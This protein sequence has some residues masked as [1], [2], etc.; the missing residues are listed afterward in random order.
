[1]L[2]VA[3]YDAPIRAFIETD[4]APILGTLVQH[5]GFVLEHQQRGARSKIHNQSHFAGQ[6]L[7]HIR[8]HQLYVFDTYIEEIVL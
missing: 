2:S 5:H 1:M 6:T 7:G 4:E 3:N 8:P